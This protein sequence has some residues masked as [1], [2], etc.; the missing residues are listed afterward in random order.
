MSDAAIRQAAFGWLTEQVERHDDVLPR[1]V[2]HAGFQFSGAR[3]PLV[4]PQGIFKPRLCELPLSV[5]T[6]CNGPYDDRTSHDGRFLYAYR[7]RDPKHRDNEGLR[8]LMQRRTP[9]IYFYCLLPGRYLVAWP[10]FVVG[11]EPGR[12]RFTIQLDDARVLDMLSFRDFAVK[13]G[14]DFIELDGMQGST[15]AG[16]AEVIDYVGVPTLPAIIEA[17]DALEEI[18]R[19]QDIELVVMGGIRD[20]VD[21]VKA[22]CLGA[23]AVAFGTSAIIAGG[24]IACMQCHI[25]QCVTGIATQDPEHE[26]RYDPQAESH[27]IHR[28][29]EGVRWQIAALTHALGYTDFRALNRDDLVALTPE[30]AEITGLPHEPGVRAKTPEL[31]VRLG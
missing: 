19:R 29:L 10:V 31:R 30:A 12:L 14:F 8:T 5:L 23:D 6:A 15:G 3:V 22:L 24:C 11:D 27:N 28:F 18:G 1:S 21:A 20:G 9:L 7:G 2:L 4:G 26:K 17:I 25:G 16:S 13:D